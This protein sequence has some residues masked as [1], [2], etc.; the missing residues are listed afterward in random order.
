MKAF[1]ILT[2]W[3]SL[4]YALRAAD[5]AEAESRMVEKHGLKVRVDG[6]SDTVWK[7]MRA[8]VELQLTLVEDKSPT[9][10]LA[11]DLA[12]FIRKEYLK[13]GYP[14]A[15]VTWNIEN[16]TAVLTASEGAPET[17]GESVFTG[18]DAATQEEMRDY[19]LRPTKERRGSLGKNAPLVEAEIA[20]GASLVERLLQSRGYLSAEVSDPAFVRVEGKP[21]DIKVT[22][23]EGPVSTFADVFINGD[24]PADAATARVDAAA[25]K[26]QPYSEV[27]VEEIRAKVEAKCQAA[28]HFAAKVT[29]VARPGARGG[30]VPVV[31]TVAPGPVYRVARVEASEDL[32]RGARRIINAGFHPAEG[33]IWSTADLQLMQ[34]RVMDSG[35]FFQP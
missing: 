12:F 35:V 1:L 33:E 2:V 19:L 15:N 23:H 18:T 25:L 7:T 6:A 29:A 13:L 31:L 22:I 30:K 27:R 4:A 32:S 28:G 16:D 34:R 9:P 10:P 20:A 8:I 21:T 24:L 26:D 17:I 5:K 11:D 14:A 3:L